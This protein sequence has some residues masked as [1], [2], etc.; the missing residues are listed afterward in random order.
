MPRMNVMLRMLGSDEFE[1]KTRPT[2]S[3]DDFK[4]PKTNILTWG[5]GLF[6]GQTVSFWGTQSGKLTWRSGSD[7][8]P[9]QTGDFQVIPVSFGGV[10]RRDYQ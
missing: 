2:R 5:F 8:F 7:D 6:Q 3:L 1:K 4:P 9:F 10:G